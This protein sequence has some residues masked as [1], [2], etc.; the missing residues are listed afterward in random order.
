MD[1]NRIGLFILAWLTVTAGGLIRYNVYKSQT[2]PI[3]QVDPTFQRQ[4]CTTSY[5]LLSVGVLMLIITFI[6]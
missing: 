2:Q 1:P 4:S 6:V 3:G 5:L